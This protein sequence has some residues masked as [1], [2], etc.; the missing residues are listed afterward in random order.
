MI[1]RGAS[2]GRFSS[3]EGSTV[4]AVLGGVQSI[5]LYYG[6]ACTAREQRSVRLEPVTSLDAV[7]RRRSFPLSMRALSTFADLLARRVTRCVR[8]YILPLALKLRDLLLFSPSFLHHQVT[9]FL[10]ELPLPV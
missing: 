5:E 3:S 4:A 7:P 8:A 6:L 1:E 10:L 2:I 9:L